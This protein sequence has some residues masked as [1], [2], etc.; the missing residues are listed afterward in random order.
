MNKLLDVDFIIQ[1]DNKT[2][3]LDIKHMDESLRKGN[4]SIL[5]QS[6]GG[7]Y[8]I[9]SNNYPVIGSGKLLL[10]GSNREK[11][12]EFTYHTFN[13]TEEMHEYITNTNKLID[14]INNPMVEIDLD[15]IDIIDK[16]VSHKS[17]DYII[18]V[19]NCI[20]SNYIEIIIHKNEFF[21]SGVK[22]WYISDDET[23]GQPFSEVSEEFDNFCK[24][25]GI[26]AKLIKGWF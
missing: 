1:K 26:K 3:V 22:F 19:E 23:T 8:S 18:K 6:E 17:G 9:W 7:K 4:F 21:K 25:R 2:I 12:N 14:E 13:S 11:Y 5:A 15:S 20:S 24:R 16:P 10:R